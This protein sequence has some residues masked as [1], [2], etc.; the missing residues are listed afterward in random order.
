MAPPYSIMA[1]EP[2]VAV[3]DISLLTEALAPVEAAA[4]LAEAAAT[5]R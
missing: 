1:G 3:G 5:V 4:A 2:A